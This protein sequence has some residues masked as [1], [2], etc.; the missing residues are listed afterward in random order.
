MNERVD[1][2]V[3]AIGGVVMR[4]RG[5]N[6]AAGGDWDWPGIR[7]GVQAAVQHGRDYNRPLSVVAKACI[8][9]AADWKNRT[10]A[11]MG[12]PGPHWHD[13]PASTETRRPPKRTEECTL[14]PGKW[15]NE[16]A[17]CKADQVVID[18]GIDVIEL[19]ANGLHGKQLFHA[20]KEQL[21]GGVGDTQEDR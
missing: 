4:L 18:A 16:C 5:R 3:E 11:V 7:T 6:V 2:D 9:A 15:R 8:N 1:H 19:E 21:R 20:V 10:P 13:G 17:G 14:H 12:M